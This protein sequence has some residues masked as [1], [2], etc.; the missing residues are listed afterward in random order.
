MDESFKKGFEKVAVSA[1]QAGIGASILGGAGYA[2]SKKLKKKKL[3]KS[4]MAGSVAKTVKGIAK[5]APKAPKVPKV[6]KAPAPNSY[7]SLKKDVNVG[8]TQLKGWAQ[9]NPGKALAGTAAGGL[10]TG[11]A[12]RGD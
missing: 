6:P 7:Q 2:L 3:E 10:A 9:K 12:L 4:A 8:A 11:Y 5:A 1:L